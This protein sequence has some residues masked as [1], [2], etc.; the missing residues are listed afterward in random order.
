M[1]IITFFSGAFCSEG[2]VIRE[3]VSDIGYAVVDDDRIAADAAQLSGVAQSKIQRAFGAKT[4]IFNKFTHEKES[5]IAYLKLALAR[6]LAD[7]HIIVR[8]FSGML[9]PG[10]IQHVLRVCLMADM[11]YRCDLAAEKGRLSDKEAL[12]LIRNQDEDSANWVHMQLNQN[13]PWDASLYD[14]MIPMDKKHPTEAAAAIME[15]AA[16]D[17]LKATPESKQVIADFMLAAEIEVALANEGHHVNVETRNGDATLTINK[18]VLMLSRLEEELRGIA[19]KVSGVKSVGTVVGKDFHQSQIYRKHDFKMPSKV[20]LVDDEREFIETLSERL[21]IRDMGAAV[22]YDGQSA[23]DLVQEDEPEVLIIDLKMP[24]IDGLEVLKKVKKTRPEIEVVVLT[25]HGSQADRDVCMDLG[26]FA[27]LQK[28]VDID[29]L[30]DILK[31][32]HAKIREGKPVRGTAED[33]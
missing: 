2:A 10:N 7:E 32:A 16:K 33:I 14:M 4:S 17:V 3:L 15:N 30:S 5:S 28:P 31:K 1:A 13:D 24:G 23:L 27:Y 19:A 22:T 18:P 9:I 21:Q 6:M 25:G 20:L 8:G 12:K 11:K 29:E 26:A